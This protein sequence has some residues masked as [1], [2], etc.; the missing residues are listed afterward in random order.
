M[1]LDFE[2]DRDGIICSLEKLSGFT[3]WLLALLAVDGFRVVVFNARGL[4]E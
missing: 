2:E 4:S 3:A 1:E